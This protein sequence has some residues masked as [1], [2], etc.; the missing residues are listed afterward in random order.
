[1]EECLLQCSGHGLAADRFREGPSTDLDMNSGFS[2]RRMRSDAKESKCI[3][4]VQETST[5]ARRRADSSAPSVLSSQLDGGI[6]Y[7][8]YR[9]SKLTNEEK[10]RVDVD[11]QW[12]FF[13]FPQ[14]E[15][16]SI[17]PTMLRLRPR[18]RTSSSFLSTAFQSFPNCCPYAF[19]TR[20]KS[21]SESG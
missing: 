19:N 2:K 11:L 16:E 7:G 12:T 6:R 18:S 1:M 17:Q 15:M 21:D 9:P 20:S 14:S 10:A 4:L 8:E 5:A 13:H 3:Q